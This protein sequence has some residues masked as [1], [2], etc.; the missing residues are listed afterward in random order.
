[1]SPSLQKNAPRDRIVSVSAVME[2][3]NGQTKGA[4]NGINEKAKIGEVAEQVLNSS[5]PVPVLDGEGHVVGKLSRE[6]MV[7]ALFGKEDL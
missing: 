7:T 3:L 6:R 4:E 5:A 1:M 2:K